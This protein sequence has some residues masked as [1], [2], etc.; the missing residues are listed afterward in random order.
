LSSVTP[1]QP[2]ELIKQPSFSYAKRRFYGTEIAACA[3]GFGNMQ[4]MERE[5]TARP[6]TFVK[7][8]HENKPA[9]DGPWQLRSV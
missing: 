2:F 9:C 6:M 5:K 1:A 8:Q 4:N 3:T 7:A